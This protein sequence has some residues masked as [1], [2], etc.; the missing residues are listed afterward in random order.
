MNNFQFFRF[1][2]WCAYISAAMVVLGLIAF[3]VFWALFSQTGT[4]NI[5]GPINDSTSV[6]LGLA[7]IIVLIALHRL[8]RRVA[9]TV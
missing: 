8:Y 2:G 5:W 7:N 1:T 3:M 4:D 9:Q 6:V